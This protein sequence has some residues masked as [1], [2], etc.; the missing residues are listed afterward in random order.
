VTIGP[1]AWAGAFGLPATCSR[2]GDGILR[3]VDPERRRLRSLEAAAV[4]WRHEPPATRAQ[5]TA[6]AIYEAR[7]ALG[8]IPQRVAGTLLYRFTVEDLAA[9]RAGT[10]S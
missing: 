6:V 1:H 5:A 10:A 8:A 2:V 9:V 4:L 7:Y 3:E